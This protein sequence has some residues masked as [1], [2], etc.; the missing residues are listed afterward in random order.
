MKDPSRVRY[1]NCLNAPDRIPVHQVALILF[2]A[3]IGLCSTHRAANAAERPNVVVILAD[4]M[5]YG[6]PGCYNSESQCVTPHID[7]LAQAG[8]RFTD[9]HSAGGVCVPSR[10]GLMTGRYP[11]R[12]NLNWRREPVIREGR[13]TIASLMKSAGYTTQMVGK[14]HLG[15]ADG[16]DYDYAKPLAGGPVDRGFDGFF[17]MHASLDIPP[18]FYMRG[19]DP[20]APPTEDVGASNTPGWS[21]IQ[22]AFWREGKIGADFKHD[23]ELDRFAAEA[24]QF[25]AQQ[26]GEQPFMLYLALPAPHTPWLPA[27]KFRGIGQAGLYSEFVAHVDDVVGRITQQ[28]EA[29]KLADNTVVVFS[30]DNGP[31]WYDSDE[32]RFGHR[33]CGP[34]RGMKGDAW[35]GGHR[36]PF[37]VRWP[38]KVAAKSQSD[39]LIGFVDLLATLRDIVDVEIPAGDAEDSVSFYSTLTGTAKTSPRKVMLQ[40]HTPTVIRDGHWKLISHL[41]SGGF[42]QPRKEKPEPDGP[43]GQLYDLHTDPGETTNLWLK[44]PERVDAMLKMLKQISSGSQP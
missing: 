23:E 29:S 5:G 32:E 20:T 25:L 30:S 17:G 18:Y 4:D 22:G 2:V 27:E 39:H 31:V 38:G 12:K 3:V 11:F 33:S 40:H 24:T 44:Y 43:Q 21:P 36:V 37:L 41:G 13:T 42:S 19:Q 35:E 1:F 6:D 15:F 28:L 34:F 16:P 9:A 14:W 7:A 8:M 26:N 10:Y